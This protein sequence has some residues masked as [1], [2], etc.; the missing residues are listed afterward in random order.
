M[1]RIKKGGVVRITTEKAFKDKFKGQGYVI[2]EEQE[3]KPLEVDTEPEKDIEDYSKGNGWYEYEG[4]SY[5]KADLIEM[6]GE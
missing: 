3:Q 2:V 1:I 4:K 5:R 6:L